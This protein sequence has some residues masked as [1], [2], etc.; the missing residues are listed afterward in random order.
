MYRALAVC[1]AALFGCAANPPSEGT[2][3]VTVDTSDP[4]LTS[5]C[6]KVFARGTQSLQTDGISIVDRDSVVVAIFQGDEPGLVEIEAVGYSDAACTAETQPAERTETGSFSFGMPAQL[7]LVLR[8]STSDASIDN[9]GDGHPATTDCNDDDPSI[10]PG[11]V[12]RCEG[13]VD[14]NC[15]TLVDC[16]DAA[17][18][19]QVCAAGARCANLRCAEQLCADG[20]DNDGTE[21]ADCFDPD[22]DQQPCMNDGTCRA[23]VCRTQNEANLCNDGLDNDG[24]TFTDCADPDC[25]NGSA[26]NDL[27][28]CSENDQC[29]NQTCSAQPRV[30]AT[31]TQCFVS[32]GVCDPDGG[33][34]RFDSTPDA[35]CDDGRACTDNDTCEVDGGCGGTL[36]TCS[37]PPNSCY[38]PVG[39]CSELLD[40]GCAYTPFPAGQ[41][42]CD[43]GNACNENDTCDGAGGCQGLAPACPPRVCHTTSAAA[44]T[45][46]DRCGFVALANGTPCAGGFCVAGACSPTPPVFPYTPSNFAEADLPPSLGAFSVNCSVVTI[47]TRTADGGVTLTQCDGGVSRPAHSLVNNGGFTAVLLLVDSLNVGASGLLRGRGARPLMLASKGD[48]FIAN[49]GNVDVNGFDDATTVARGAGAHL[50]CASGAGRPGRVEANQTAGGGGGAA[51]GGPAGAGGPSSVGGDAGV[52]FGN[53]TLVPLFGGC[54]GG[55]GGN[56]SSTN[57]GTGGPGG[58][59]LQ[60]SAAG[61]I[62]L[63]GNVTA[64]GSGG[65]GGLLDARVGGGG[66]GSGGAVLLEAQSLSSSSNGDVIANGGGAGE[67]SGTSASGARG[68]NGRTHV[69]PAAGGSSGACGGAGGRGASRDATAGNGVAAECGT[70]LPGG[71]GGGGMGRIRINAF[72]GGCNFNGASWFSPPRTGVGSNCQ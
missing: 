65:T 4:A 44:C 21:G 62:R 71:G 27:N 61:V 33:L 42:T 14:D 40:G 26:C 58:G 13:R 17:C 54:R 3:R 59:A 43:D 12:E 47:T 53:V 36:R 9:D 28:A 18:N 66:G 63:E 67:G 29:S 52:P 48:V 46:T 2:L 16:D 25:P 57:L 8:R 31:A 55:A 20:L 32:A 38:Q 35:G 5:R 23:G 6:V 72:D 11:A 41:G 19:A 68:A 60:I 45:A 49:G 70:N 10:H 56:A 30:C 22:C 24:D 7:T 39:A 15:D 69:E 50:N 64:N 51:F 37:A 1:A 34:C